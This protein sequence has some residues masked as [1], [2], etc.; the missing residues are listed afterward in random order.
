M[1]R[2]N[3]FMPTVAS[4]AK[5]IRT[6]VDCPICRTPGIKGLM[7]INPGEPIGTIKDYFELMLFERLTKGHIGHNRVKF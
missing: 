4:I 6:T 7:V 5:A 3:L 2:I 1:I